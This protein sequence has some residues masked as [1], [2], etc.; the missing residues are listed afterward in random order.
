[1]AC[2]VHWLSDTEEGR[3]IASGVVARLHDE[4]A[5][6]ADLA[7]ARAEIASERARGLGPTR[8]CPKEAA[9]LA[10]A[11]LLLARRQPVR[12]RHRDVQHDRLAGA[13]TGRRV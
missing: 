5:F 1:M 12:F 11:D 7:A 2:N 4:A 8:D 3:V 10:A 13:A 9:Q 6:R